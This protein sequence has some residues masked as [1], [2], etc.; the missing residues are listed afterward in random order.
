[1]RLAHFLAT[2]WEK[3][4]I[5]SWK[6]SVICVVLITNALGKLGLLV[7]N[8]YFNSVLV[9]TVYCY[10]SERD[11]RARNWPCFHSG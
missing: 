7:N 5:P 11:S 10:N 8:Q 1:M 6:S 3:K 4:K 9:N 2:L